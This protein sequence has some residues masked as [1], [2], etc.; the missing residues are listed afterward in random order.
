MNSEEEIKEIFEDLDI[1]EDQYPEYIDPDTF[2]DTFEKCSV[3]K[4]HS[5][6]ESAST[7]IN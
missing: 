7:T 1:T 5:I 4:S 3:L 6:I 2:A